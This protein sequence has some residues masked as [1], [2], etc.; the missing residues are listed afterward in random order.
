[1]KLSLSE[2]KNEKLIH[3]ARKDAELVLSMQESDLADFISRKC[4][5]RRLTVFV[6]V[7]N[8]MANGSVGERQ[9]AMEALR[10]IGLNR[11]G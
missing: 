5:Q 1:M 11:G 4:A 10:R 8:Q 7:L 9:V 3:E 2:N 6:R